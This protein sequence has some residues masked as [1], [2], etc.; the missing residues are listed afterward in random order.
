MTFSCH[1]S[2]SNFLVVNKK[3]ILLSSSKYF[4]KHGCGAPPVDGHQEILDILFHEN[5]LQ[6]LR[7]EFDCLL[8]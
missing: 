5:T 2:E 7:L 1:K 6:E 8:Q 4:T 3:K